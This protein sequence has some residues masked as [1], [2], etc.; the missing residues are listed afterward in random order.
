MFANLTERLS[1]ITRNLQGKGR[2]S[3]SNIKDTLREIRLALLEAD[4]ALSVVKNFIEEIKEEVIGSKIEK[5]L[6]PGQALTKIIHL[7]LIDLFGNKT[8]ELN[9]KRPSPIVIMMVGLQGSGKTTTAAKLAKRLIDIKKK[10][11]MLVSVDVHRPAAILQLNRLADEIGADFF[12]SKES[13]DP[14]QI[15]ANA[16]NQSQ[17]SQSDIIII[18]TAGRMHVDDSMMDEMSEVYQEANP[19]E[20]FFVVDSMAGQDAINPAKAFSEKLD[21]TGIIL[22]KT[23]GDARGGV[24]L[25]V[26]QVTGK[27]IF[28][29]GVGEKIDDIELFHPERMASR[30]LGMGDVLSLVEELEAKVDRKQSE[31][32]VNKLKKGKKFDLYDL[33]DQLQQ[34]VGMGGMSALLEKLPN[35]GQLNNAAVNQQF[36][37][38]QLKRQI[39]IINS[40]TPNERRFPKTINGSRKRRIAA[41]CGLQ[42]QDINKLMKQHVQM[43][44]MMKKMSGG[45]MKKM[46][47]GLSGMNLPPGLR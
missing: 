13:Q 10:R 39:G 42:I 41:G 14:K 26:S 2:L 20:T 22:T 4:V 18:D 40:M 32:L 36:N 6:T 24:A 35:A 34:M 16:L 11:V 21:I 17:R 44:R 43:E 28:Y 15:V 7:K 1:S 5:S 45:K 31:R 46:M 8:V 29:L 30:I 3:D 37:E 27:P 33:K 38:K 23:D 9:L 25:S 19:S 12:S 47:R